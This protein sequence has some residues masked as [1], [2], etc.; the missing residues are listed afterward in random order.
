MLKNLYITNK[1]QFLPP[2]SIDNFPSSCK[3]HDAVKLMTRLHIGLSNL[4]EHKFKCGFP[5][6]LFRFCSCGLH[7]ELI[8]HYFFTTPC[9]MM[10]ETK[11]LIE[12]FWDLTDKTIWHCMVLMLKLYILQILY[13]HINYQKVWWICFTFNTGFFLYLIKICKYQQQ[14]RQLKSHH[15]LYVLLYIVFFLLSWPLPIRT[16][17]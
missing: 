3:N 10:K 5:Y 4:C 17:G 8:S 9:A 1:K 6:T 15:V 11:T 7:I 14:A 13:P 12:D 2:L 16:E